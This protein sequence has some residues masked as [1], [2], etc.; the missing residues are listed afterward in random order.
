[1]DMRGFWLDP[2]L[3]GR[4]L[5][6]EAAERVTAFAFEEMAWPLLYLT[7]AE[8][9]RASHRIKEKQGATII[10]RSAARF[11]EGDGV[12]VTWILTREAWLKARSF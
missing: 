12:R 6:T 5:M 3:Q 4:G 11:R 9:N 8:A 10:S 7:N 2:A 1:M